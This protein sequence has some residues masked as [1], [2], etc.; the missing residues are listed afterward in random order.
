MHLIME[1][2][3]INL[4]V[5][6]NCVIV[7]QS[8]CS[9][10]LPAATMTS[11]CGRRKL[12]SGDQAGGFFGKTREPFSDVLNSRQNTDVAARW[13][14]WFYIVRDSPEQAHAAP[15]PWEP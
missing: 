12:C 2:A 3:T 11:C 7:L 15:G 8:W 4:S 6:P 9:C 5:S 10:R 13:F 1:H 14:Q